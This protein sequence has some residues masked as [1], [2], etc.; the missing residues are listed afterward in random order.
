MYASNLT[1]QD[2]YL[3]KKYLYLYLFYPYYVS[4]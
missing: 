3:I 4:S 1:E 2:F